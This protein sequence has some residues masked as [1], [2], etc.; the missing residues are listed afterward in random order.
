VS[1]ALL[2]GIAAAM[3]LD[4]PVLDDAMIAEING[5]N[6]GWTAGR[7]AR[8]EGMTLREARKMLGGLMSSTHMPRNMF[9][10]G[11][12]N[13]PHA[14]EVDDREKFSQC[15]DTI[16]NIM[17][18]GRC[19]SCWAFSASEVATDRICIASDG[20]FQKQLSPQDLVS[21]DKKDYGCNGGYL[22]KSMEHIVKEGIRTLECYPYVSGSGR[23]PKCETSG[24]PNEKSEDD[25]TKYHL[26]E[27]HDCAGA[28]T[29]EK[30]VEKDGPVN[31][32]F[33][34][35]QDFFSYKKGVYQHK[36][37]GLAGGHAVKIMG[38]G[39][40]GNTQYWHVANSWGSSWGMDGFFRILRGNDECNIE[41]Q[42]VTGKGKWPQ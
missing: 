34:V 8:F 4:A 38:F 7:N 14:D 25:D 36:S 23:E 6:S 31:V 35:Y 39:K 15:A 28:K 12:S 40:E 24:C 21:C 26:K 3:N 9:S 2:V 30:E 13:E 29:I 1:V 11:Q 19:G 32:G 20:E 37:G 22:D 10:L 42:C 41:S 33:Y 16:G 5:A 27:F 18:Q 17:D